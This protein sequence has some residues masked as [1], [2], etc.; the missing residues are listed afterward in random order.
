MRVRVGAGL[1]I[2]LHARAE[3]SVPSSH[4]GCA[5]ASMHLSVNQFE[6]ELH[7]SGRRRLQD[8]AEIRRSD[9]VFRQAEVRVV[10]EVEAL[11]AELQA[12]TLG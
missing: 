5:H 8:A 4:V 7:Q 11:G 6:P 9:V 12:D 3:T 2:V 1:R 10:G